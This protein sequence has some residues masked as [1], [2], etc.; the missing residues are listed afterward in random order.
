MQTTIRDVLNKLEA[1]DRAIQTVA[2][3]LPRDYFAG[4]EPLCDV[5]DLLGEYRNKIL[6][7]KVDV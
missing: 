5:I 6:D 2:A 1:I 7:D 4:Q 3:L